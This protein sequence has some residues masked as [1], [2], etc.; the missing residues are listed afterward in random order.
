MEAEKVPCDDCG[1]PVAEEVAP[2]EK[3]PA[4]AIV[5]KGRHH[6]H[7]FRK[8]VDLSKMQDQPAASSGQREASISAN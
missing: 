1:S 5:I 7:R 8:I 2:C 6:G 3:Y 4:G